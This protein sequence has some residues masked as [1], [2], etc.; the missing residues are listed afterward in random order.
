M[1]GAPLAGLT[2][3][4]TRAAHQAEP[5]CA[6][7][8]REG[9][10]PLRMPAID[11]GP[12]RDPAA[13][14]AFASRADDYAFAVFVSPNAVDGLGRWMP[15][16]LPPAM[17]LIAVGPATARALTDAGYT[18][19]TCAESPF[20][21]EA[22][23]ALPMLQRVHGTRGVIFRGD[24]GRGLLLKV[25]TERGAQVEY[26]E[27]YTRATPPAPDRTVA[28]A[29]RRGQV[30]AVTATSGETLERMVELC[31]DDLHHGLT[32]AQLVVSSG[33]MVKLAESLGF[34]APLVASE[35]G[36]HALVEALVAWR[37]GQ[38]PQEI[39]WTHD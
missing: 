5:L 20:N 22:M 31:G 18:R 29:L 36:D 4:V 3:L 21:S 37:T 10:R 2:V 25:L 12:P 7:L 24:A 26:V 13:V 23:L 28:D 6:L 30:G 32:R 39:G 38:P 11:I 35:P 17:E 9:A 34:R 15:G 16:K 8:E 14:Q 27:T 19:V 1:S 33:R